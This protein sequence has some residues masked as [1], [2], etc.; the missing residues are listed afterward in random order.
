MMGA[1]SLRLLATLV[2]RRHMT[3]MCL[4]PDTGNLSFMVAIYIQIMQS[5]CDGANT[6]YV[7]VLCRILPYSAV[8]CCILLSIIFCR[9]LLYSAIHNILPNSVKFC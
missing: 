5:S 1:R 2:P 6:Y 7:A 9:I 8:F 4:I 3:T